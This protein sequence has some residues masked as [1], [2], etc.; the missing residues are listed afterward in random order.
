MMASQAEHPVGDPGE[1]LAALR[2]RLAP[3]IPG[4]RFWGWAGPLLV[5][6]F[7]AFL[8]FHRLGLPPG[9]IFD[10]TYYAADALGI[11]RFGVEH[12]YGSHHDALLASGN[13][14]IFTSGGEFVAH[15]PFAKMLIAVGEWMFGINPFGWRFAVA[16]VGSLSILILAR[17]ARRMTRSTL[18]G[19][20][21]GLL[22]ALDGLEFVMSRTTLLDIFVMFWVL[23]AFACLVADRDRTRA[24]LADAAARAA[25]SD[26]PVPPPRL[27]FRWWWL[28]AGI[29]L[30]LGMASKWNGIWYV[31]A[32]I[33][34]TFAW[35]LGARRAAGFG[36]PPI[37]E[38]V[39]ANLGLLGLLGVVPALAYLATWSGWLA[40]GTGYDRNW[41]A[42]H[43][44]HTPV[45]SGLVSL[46]QYHKEML[47][48]NTHLTTH[49][50]YQSK[51]WTWL[52]MSRPVSFYWCS[53][54]TC[55][56]G[57]AQEVLALGTPLIWWASI[58]ALL[59]CLGWW[60]TRR[61]WRAGAVVLGVAAGWLP[62]FLFAD[63]TQFSFYAVAFVPFLVLSIT[64]CLGLVIGRAQ[65]A[66][67]R[68][69]WGA[70]AA[71]GYLVAVAWNFFYLYPVLA[72]QVIPYGQWL[73]RMWYRGWI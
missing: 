68:R 34:L 36:P 72:A 5:T 30:G 9:I 56:P 7:G 53:D 4:S 61:D 48:F 16:V 41:A 26:S 71:G 15:P 57:K 45:I 31:P 54:P 40:T 37:R 70:A 69:R 21:A 8:R 20:V 29:C 24:A 32:F 35:E 23:A 17:V 33:A 62:W 18:L 50:P 59:V 44:I 60:L 42:Q 65:A 10:E 11:L 22:L 73:S 39:R 3:P 47:Y 49:H 58:I 6:A 43:G 27:G 12:N 51:P 63:R 38:T 2:A 28:A 67:W 13:P 19:C 46:F 25:A 55:P 14:H 1:G 64:L 66:A 52:V